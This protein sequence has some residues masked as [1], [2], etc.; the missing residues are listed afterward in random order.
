M[1]NHELATEIANWTEAL[2]YYLGNLRTAE[3]TGAMQNAERNFADAARAAA[4]L[5]A[6]KGLTA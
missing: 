2:E 6:L 1:G 3:R 4:I 5:T